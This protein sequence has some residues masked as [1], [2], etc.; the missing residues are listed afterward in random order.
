MTVTFEAPKC[1]RIGA[2]F[3]AEFENNFNV[4]HLFK[5]FKEVPLPIVDPTFNRMANLGF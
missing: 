3:S 2:F 5:S 1:K 4:V